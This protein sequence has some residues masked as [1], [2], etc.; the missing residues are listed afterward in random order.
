[1]KRSAAWLLVLGAVGCGGD[2]EPERLGVDTAAI[3]NG[4]PDTTHDAVVACFSSMGGCTATVVHTDGFNAYV[5]TAAHC[6]FQINNPSASDPI[7]QC[8]SATDYAGTVDWV[9]TVTDSEVHPQYDN[10]QLAYDFAMLKLVNVPSGIPVI[11]AMSPSEDDLQI[12]S[13]VLHVGYGVTTAGGGGN[14]VRRKTSNTLSEIFQLQVGYNQPSSGPC[15]G[16]SGG[17]TIATVG[18][19]ERVGGVVSFGDESCNITGYSGRTSAV[20]PWITAFTGE[21]STS[22]S[23]ATTGAGGQTGATTGAG[24]AGT[25]VGGGATGP[26]GS[27]FAGDNENQ[28]PDGVLVTSCSVSLPGSSE[29]PMFAWPIAIALLG[30]WRRRRAE[31]APS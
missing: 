1:M 3:I 31:E 27:W 7:N 6:M 22:S 30:L 10:Q 5:L 15:N 21:S 23:A 29:T 12:G 16:D 13:Q 17:P 4:T 24:G 11:P 20:Y 9:A 2:A 19:Q 14:S 18:G 8:A 28:D 25:G 26:N